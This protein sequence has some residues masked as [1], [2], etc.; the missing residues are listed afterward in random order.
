MSILIKKNFGGKIYF[1]LLK[2]RSVFLKTGNPIFSIKLGQRLPKSVSQHHVKNSR[3]LFSY[4]LKKDDWP[5]AADSPLLYVEYITFLQHDKEKH[6]NRG[7][8][9]L[10]LSVT[11]GYRESAVVLLHHEAN[12]YTENTQGW[13]G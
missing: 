5:K 4:F 3:F 10:M 12:V 7:R 13:S 11:L 6:D 8:T 1:Y 9:P 2:M